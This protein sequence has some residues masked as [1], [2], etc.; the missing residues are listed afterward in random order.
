MSRISG[1]DHLNKLYVG[2]RQNSSKIGNQF[3]VNMIQNVVKKQLT[4]A[5]HDFLLRKQR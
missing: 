3:F 5:E 2:I 4:M 1:I